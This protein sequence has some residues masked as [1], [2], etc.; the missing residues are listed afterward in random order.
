[1]RASRK[2]MRDH[3]PT[4]PGPAAVI[5]NRP[6]RWNTCNAVMHT[7]PRMGLFSGC[8]R[9]FEWVRMWFCGHLA[10]VASDMSR[11]CHHICDSAT[12]DV[13]AGA[14]AFEPLRVDS[15]LPDDNTGQA[16]KGPPRSRPEITC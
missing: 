6:Y 14:A 12:N 3:T 1:M 9:S 4:V 16:E 13:G 5:P 15:Q 8:C 10:C 2:R 7:L 11:F